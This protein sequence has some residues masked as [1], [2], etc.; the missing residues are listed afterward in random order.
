MANLMITKRC[1]LRCEYCFANEFVGKKE[2]NEM[3]LY[4]FCEL[5]DFMLTDGSE[6]TVG[7]IGGEP[8]LHPE[9]ESML[10]IL[11]DD[12]RVKGV[13]IYT[14]GILLKKYVEILSNE[15]FHL[16]VN[17]NDLSYDSNIQDNFMN[18]L[19]SAFEVMADRIVLGINIY[20]KSYDYNCIINLLKK[21]ECRK[22]RI[23]ICVPN[24]AEYGYLPIDHFEDMKQEVIRLFDQLYDI[25]VIPHFDC[26]I[27]PSCV[28][29]SS[30]VSRYSSWGHENPFSVVKNQYTS[31][32]PVIDFLPDKT[33]VRC[34]GLSEYTRAKVK[35]FASVTNLR[36]YYIREYDAYAVNV[37]H[38][39]KCSNCYKQ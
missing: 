19:D 22:L 8:T 35:D 28:I 17:C 24:S 20:R 18:S 25:N 16:L 6:N 32:K 21:Y 2:K 14:N 33:A 10:H 36:N 39:E 9:L 13:T 34:F 29:S 23:S 15:K 7:I 5:L 26:N 11:K 4:T 31:C 27:M 1:N 38:S 37:C 3:S 30:D 12:Q